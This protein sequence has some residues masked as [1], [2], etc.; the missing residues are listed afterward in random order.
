[1]VVFAGL[2]WLQSTST[3][4]ARSLRVIVATTSAGNV[5]VT[6]RASSRA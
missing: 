1:M 3:L 6:S 2:F 5:A 4:P